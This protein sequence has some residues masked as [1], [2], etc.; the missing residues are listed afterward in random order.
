MRTLFFLVLALAI[1]L[2][3]PA[4]DDAVKRGK[5]LFFDTQALEYP[6]CAQCHSTLPEKE[7]LKKAKHLGPGSTLY[8]AILREGWRN[9]RTYADLG[10]ASQTC[11]K[12]WQKRKGGLKAAQ[13]ADLIAF[14]SGFV[15]RVAK[16]PLPMR[17]VQRKPKMIEEYVG[18]DR[19]KGEALA[20]R[21]CGGCHNETDDSIA[22]PLRPN[23]KKYA[24]IVRSVRGYDAKLKFKPKTMSYY[25]NDRLK[26]E[27]LKHILAYL[28]K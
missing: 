1:A 4:E 23:K 10:E 6:S 5:K 19:E 14:L 24:V 26:D 27:D 8:G 22:I 9:R 15:P 18:G 2:A 12:K 11:A 3:A 20:Q 21:Y 28:G 25:T 13:R 7:E 16:G 17:K